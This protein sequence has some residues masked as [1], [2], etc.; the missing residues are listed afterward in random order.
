MLKD[1]R[2]FIQ[3]LESRGELTRI[4]AEVD[5]N[6]EI[7]AII[8]EALRRNQPALLFENIKDYGETHGKKL[9]TNTQLGSFRRVLIAFGMPD[10]TH[11]LEALRILKERCRQRIMARVVPTGPCKEVIEKGDQINILEFPSPKWHAR[12]GG[13][14][15]HTWGAIV[16]KDPE[17]GWINA[18][19]Q[20]GQAHTKDR[21]TVGLIEKSHA[22]L[23]GKKY[24]AMGKKTMPMAVVLGCPPV[25]P[26]VACTPIETGVDEYDVVGAIQQEPLE[27][28]KCET[29]D[30][31][32]PAWAE[33]V[34]EGQFHLD[35]S[36]F[37]MEGPFGE[38]P[39]TY[40]TLKPSP[41]PFLEVTCVTHREDPV[42]HG[43]M[44]GM[45][46]HVPQARS[47]PYLETIGLWNSLEDLGIP[48][49]TGVYPGDSLGAGHPIIIVSI[50]N[51]YYGHARHV[52]TALWS[53]H[54]KELQSKIVIVVDSEI[55]I[56]DKNAVFN[57]I[58]QRVRP[59]E[60]I[61]IFPGTIGGALDPS[62]LP[63]I[64]EAT[65]M[66]GRWDRVLIDATWPIEWQARAEWD[67]GKHPVYCN[68]RKELLEKIRARWKELGLS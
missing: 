51:M 53:V 36:E 67:G 45:G 33:I 43:L 38:Y 11:P 40:V 24:L 54:G 7:G 63:E 9:L 10:D 64:R 37:M 34:I 61:T 3:A 12:D 8:E 30:L 28:V 52:A 60:D 56:T 21:M 27:I 14:Y 25:V 13:R 55:D 66:A 41:R 62:V 50:D 23:H 19:L 4:K 16:T 6:E 35:P 26:F 39:G 5:W 68:A 65:G 18:G 17:T 49:I 48:G 42:L 46:P 32:V 29:V 57:A 47:F 15:I 2:E 22:V 59:M 20:R 44:E 31:E 1:L 58:A